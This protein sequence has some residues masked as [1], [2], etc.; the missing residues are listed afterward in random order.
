M[1]QTALEIQQDIE[2][3]SQISTV[4]NILEVVCRTT[5]M[6]FAALARVTDTKWIAC[7][8]RDEIEFWFEAWRRTRFRNYHLS[9]NTPELQTRSHRQC[10]GRYT[11]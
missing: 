2:L 4:T 7:A 11:V 1:E 5:G 3:I 9:R 6:G 10:K 8:V